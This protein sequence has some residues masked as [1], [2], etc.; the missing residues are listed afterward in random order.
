MKKLLFIFLLFVS[1]C[2]AQTV[3]GYFTESIKGSVPKFNQNGFIYGY[4]AIVKAADTAYTISSRPFGTSLALTRNCSNRKIFVGIKIDTAFTN[5]NATL[6]SQISGNSTDWVTFST[7][8]S[9]TDPQTTGIQWYELDLSDVFAPYIR[10]QFN[11]SGLTIGK[12]GYI[13]FLYEIP[14]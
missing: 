1:I 4:T 3:S 8:D 7:V 9:D 14:Q 10:L 6:V 5:V 12:S 11:A 13:S 2:S